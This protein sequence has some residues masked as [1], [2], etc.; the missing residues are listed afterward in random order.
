[1]VNPLLM[2][3][4]NTEANTA[5][6]GEGGRGVPLLLIVFP[7]ADLLDWGQHVHWSKEQGRSRLCVQYL[8]EH[9]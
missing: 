7:D 4:C 5:G 8:R 6:L 2:D 9:V 1:M 3:A